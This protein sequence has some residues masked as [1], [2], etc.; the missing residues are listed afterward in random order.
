M[1]DQ[2]FDSVGVA[3]RYQ[4]IVQ[5]SCSLHAILGN[6]G[7]ED[8]SIIEATVRLQK[9]WATR[10]DLLVA[11]GFLGDT[12]KNRGAY[13][14]NCP[15][16]YLFNVLPSRVCRRPFICPFC[17]ARRIR[18]VWL[19]V[20]AAFADGKSQHTCDLVRR[21]HT[22]SLAFD[23]ASP[24][25]TLAGQLKKVTDVVPT[26]VKLVNPKGAI[27]QTIVRPGAGIT[28]WLLE[29]RQFYKISSEVT[30]PAEL[31]GEIKRIKNPGPR[32][33]MSLIGAGCPYPRELLTGDVAR[34]LQLLE[35]YQVSKFRSI[36]PYREFRSFK[37]EKT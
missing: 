28:P 11:N 31:T 33:I 2:P 5:R 35:A 22:I 4:D 37:Q 8:D 26:M 25:S 27:F 13:M 9:M 18:D 30:L 6:S 3:R 32:K 17:Y 12:G 29:Y 7:Y 15:V 36:N 23:A 1:A 14:R 34:T 16:G 20:A 10:I 21:T 24:V 19:T